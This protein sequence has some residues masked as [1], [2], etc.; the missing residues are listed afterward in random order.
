MELG[1]QFQDFIT[2][3]EF[4]VKMMLKYLMYIFIVFANNQHVSDIPGMLQKY[5]NSYNST[6]T[7]QS[8]R[9][10]IFTEP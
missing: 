1:R 4:N 3:T 6:T 7:G 5:T 9:E 10:Q 2:Y 8:S